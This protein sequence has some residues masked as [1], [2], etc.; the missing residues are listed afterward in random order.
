MSE[1]KEEEPLLLETFMHYI[2]GF[3][4]CVTFNGDTFDLPFVRNKC[5]Q[6]ALPDFLA[7]LSSIDIYRKV[8]KLKK[9]LQL[10]SLKQKSIEQFLGIN[11]E[12]RYS[13]GELIQVYLDFEATKNPK[14][15]ELLLL[16]N[17]E[18]VCG[19]F[20][21][22]VMFSYL[23]LLDGGF[24]I[25]E[26]DCHSCLNEKQETGME[27]TV[28]A[29]LETPV[30]VPFLWHNREMIAKAK[31]D[32]FFVRLPVFHGSKKLFFADYKNY[33]Y[34]PLEDKAVH[35]SIGSFV[36]AAHRKQ[37]TAATCYQNVE[38]IFLPFPDLAWQKK[39][40]IEL[41]DFATL[42]VFQDSYKEKDRYIRL[43]DVKE[44]DNYNDLLKI[45]ILWHF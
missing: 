25:E 9:I 43:T 14:L 15:R 1:R 26:A 33:Y 18:D 31:E 24:T 2:A 34:L 6:Y 4:R 11:R 23:K 40:G 27:L 19:M 8:S 20:E 12:D 45:M 7:S 17:F 29:R 38:G 10:P 42:P 5:R 32:A 13:G 44:A 22:L 37:A 3:T 16:H 30:P 28:R 35:K 21:L 39:H 36:D 41:S